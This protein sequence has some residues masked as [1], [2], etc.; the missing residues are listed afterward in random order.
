M[1]ENND[2]KKNKDEWAQMNGEN[3]VL[4]TP[5]VVTLRYRSMELLLGAKEYTTAIDMWS[6]GIIFAELIN[7]GSFFKSHIEIEQIYEIIDL[8]G[9]PTERHWPGLARLDMV[10]RKK[11]MLP[12]QPQNLLHKRF[13][14]A[15][16]RAGFDLLSQLLHYNPEKRI[17]AA[18]ALD[19]PFFIEEPSPQ[20]PAPRYYAS[21]W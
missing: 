1:S 16:S 9:T 15:L 6:C 3:G 18:D 10:R 13:G 21:K 2:K 20:P 11:V 14:G 7:G 5:T 19:H 8:L 17:S 12:H 4:Y